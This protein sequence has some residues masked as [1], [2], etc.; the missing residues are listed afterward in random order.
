MTIE[1]VLKEWT[2]RLMALPGVWSVGIG[3][4]TQSREPCIKVSVSKR[5]SASDDIPREIGGHKVEVV[6]REEP[7]PL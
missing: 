6:V 3:L 7:R 2:D 4:S 1:Q 5:G